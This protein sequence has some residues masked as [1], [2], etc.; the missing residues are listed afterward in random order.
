MHEVNKNIQKNDP[1]E[2]RALEKEKI[3]LALRSLDHTELSTMYVV[4]GQTTWIMRRLQKEKY[5]E[6]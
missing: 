2:K 6:K 3:E 1:F 5:S 4:S